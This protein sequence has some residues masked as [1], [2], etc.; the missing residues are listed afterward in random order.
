MLG[1]FSLQKT[2][3]HPTY[4]D[5]RAFTVADPRLN[6]PNKKNDLVTVPT[7]PSSYSKPN[8]DAVP[9]STAKIAEPATEIMFP[10]QSLQ[11]QVDAAKE[12]GELFYKLIEE[13]TDLV[14]LKTQ[15]KPQR[16]S[17]PEG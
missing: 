3:S 9:K 4:L 12:M 1:Y 10:Q 6:Q 8:L 17:L 16:R 11:A 7:V 2:L 13:A 15:K 5:S 14:A